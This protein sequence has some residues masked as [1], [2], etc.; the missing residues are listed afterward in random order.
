[1]PTIKDHTLIKPNIHGVLR[2]YCRYCDSNG[3]NGWD[4]VRTGNGTIREHLRRKH[5]DIVNINANANVNPTIMT[6]NTTSTTN[7]TNMAN[8][9]P[10]NLPNNTIPSNANNIC[11]IL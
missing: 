11:L 8:N 9:L 10:N 4:P 2:R 7:N 1:M 3:W 6:S 5:N